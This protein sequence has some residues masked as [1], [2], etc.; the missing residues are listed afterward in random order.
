[1]AQERGV[2]LSADGEPLVVRGDAE[3]LREA[4][5][6]IVANAILYNKMGGSVTVWTRQSGAEARI[7][8]ADT[9]IGIPADAIPHVFD[10]F[11]RVDKARSRDAGGS[12][13]GL[14]IAR[15]IVAAHGGG[16]SCTSEPGT[17]SLFVIS[18]PVLTAER[19][20][21]SPNPFP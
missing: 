14:S 13:L 18:L 17:G 9:G 1:M 8:V 11:Y 5:S 10:R 19:S 2:R 21:C 6:N 12:G 16:I 15:A 20:L 3:Q 7:E 4:L